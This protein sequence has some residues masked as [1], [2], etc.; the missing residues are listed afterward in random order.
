MNEAKIKIVPK[1]LLP[2][3]KLST[4]LPNRH[5]TL[6]H[7]DREQTRGQEGHPAALGNISDLSL[8]S[9][10]LSGSEEK[11]YVL[12]IHLMTSGHS[13]P[14]SMCISVHILSGDKALESIRHPAT[15]ALLFGP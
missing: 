9:A 11:V 15:S 10:H 4:R 5:F 7:G 2:H 3:I 13:V 6:G 8:R 12:S 1:Q 14:F